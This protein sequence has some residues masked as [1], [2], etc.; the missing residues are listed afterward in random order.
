MDSKV[1]VFVVGMILL[2]SLSSV[3][4]EEW[5]SPL[6]TRESRRTLVLTESGRITAV[7]VHDGYG[8]S[9]HLQFITLEPVSLF[10]PVLLH[11][12]MVFY[13]HT[14][15]GTVTYVNEDKDET[16]EMDVGHGDVYRLE[17]G[18]VFFVRSHP[19]P[20]R[21]KLRI[22]AI[23]DTAGID[24]PLGC[25]VRAY[26]NISD[27]VQGFDERV[28]QMGFGAS[29]ESIRGIKWAPSP[30]SIV[31]FGQKDARVKS[32]WKEG[33]FEALMG[34][35]GPTGIVNKKR[36]T[37][38]KTF[39]F[40]RAKPDVE[41]CN[42]WSTAVTHKDLKALKGSNLAAFMVN[43]ATGSMMGPHWNPRATEIATVIQGQG[44]VQVICPS[45]PSGKVGDVSKCQN[46]KFKVQEGDVFVVPRF[47]PMA[48]VSYNNDTLVFVGFSSMA[49]KN[50]PQF[51]AGKRSVLRTIDRDVLAASFNAPN[52][53]AIGDLL[54][55]QGESVMLACTS[56]AEEM[57]RKMTE[58]IERQKQEEERKKEEEERKKEEEEAKKRE[59]ETR[60]REEEEAKKRE[61]EE[62]K[63]REEEAA[64]RR[65]EEEARRREEEE[66]RREEEEARRREEEE[67][68]KREE[69]EAKRREE[70]EGR[71]REGEEEAR[72][73]EEEETKRREEEEARRE[74]EEARRREEEEG[75][76]T[77]G[78]EEARREAEEA[79]R[80]EEEEEGRREEEE[81][82]RREEEEEGRRPEEEEARRREEEEAERREQEEAARRREEEEARRRQG[83]R[84][85]KREGQR[86]GKEQGEKKKRGDGRNKRR[87]PREVERNSLWW[88]GNDED[89][90][91]S[92]Q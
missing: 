25:A 64:K 33:V 82:R 79:R 50:H 41:N 19:D 81:A 18:T 59:E 61:E 39:N 71:K 54:V 17:Q 34:V 55:S 92:R 75:R 13:V 35:R 36:K 69:E 14:G 83:G 90:H 16:D 42:G 1:A 23:F 6:V 70:E 80:R 53:S 8:G 22:H 63:R 91:E 77:E 10:L 58:E 74:A 9:Y 2:C 20:T 65:E 40:F 85:K 38:S 31:P 51:L 49:G 52:A 37:K 46:K 45:D 57:E 72:K 47:H 48:Q 3:N 88:T 89:K 60:R 15:R 30:P 5:P 62:A 27:L 11:T 86:K 28:L 68:K 43:L 44:M 66:E 26:S 87:L 67:A 78:E 84:R 76:K 21:E 12:D 56:C 24:H 32:K 73:R 29:L 4:G 7:D